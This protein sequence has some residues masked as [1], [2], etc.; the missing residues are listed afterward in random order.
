MNTLMGLTGDGVDRCS[1]LQNFDLMFPVPSCFGH[2][3]PVIVD[4]INTEASVVG[5]H[6]AD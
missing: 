3:F 1:L 6:G 2:L 5:Y 4:I